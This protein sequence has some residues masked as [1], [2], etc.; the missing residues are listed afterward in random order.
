MTPSIVSADGQTR[1]VALKKSKAEAEFII[2]DID[3]YDKIQQA[4]WVKSGRS[5]NDFKRFD[6]DKDDIIDGQEF[7]VAQI[8]CC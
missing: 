2:L 1:K 3:K 4:I 7:M 8:F 6:K 5:A